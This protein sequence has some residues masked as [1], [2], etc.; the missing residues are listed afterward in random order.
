M[1]DTNHMGRDYLAQ[2]NIKRYATEYGISH[3]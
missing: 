3:F 2:D 1:N